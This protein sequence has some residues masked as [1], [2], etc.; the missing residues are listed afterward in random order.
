MPEQFVL[1]EDGTISFM[2]SQDLYDKFLGLALCVVFNVEDRGKE[3][4]FELVPNVNGERR[5]VL[6]G[7][8]GSFD[9]DHMWIQ[10]LKSNVLWGLLEG[11]VDFDQFE[12][13]YLQFSLRIRV[14]GGTVKKLG[15]VLRCGQL[16]DDLKVVLEDNQFVDST[17][18]CEDIDGS[19]GLREFLRKCHLPIE[20]LGNSGS[21]SESEDD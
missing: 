2:A 12:E 16:E 9:S 4:S 1:V 13:S 8:L 7:I 21:E 19:T 3:I 11:G 18:L 10:Y 6:S 17:A 14:S 20:K 15:Y 5:N